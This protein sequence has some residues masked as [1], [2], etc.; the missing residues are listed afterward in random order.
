MEINFGTYEQPDGGLRMVKFDEDMPFYISDDGK[1]F[2]KGTREVLKYE[3]MIQ[4]LKPF[5]DALEKYKKSP[6]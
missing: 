3:D 6:Y 2:L 5:T 4:L 1:Y